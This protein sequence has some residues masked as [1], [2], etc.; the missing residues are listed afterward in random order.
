MSE[1]DRRAILTALQ[2]ALEPR[3]YVLALWEGGSAAW[4]REDRWSD[5]DVQILVDDDRVADA[6]RVVDEALAALSPIEI[7]FE[8]PKPTWHGHDQVF[9]R[10][11]DAGEFRLVDLAVMRRS[12]PHQLAER[13]RHGERRILFDKTGDARSTALDRARHDARLA[14]RTAQLRLAFPLFQSLVTKEL[15]R[16]NPLG[17]LAFYS[18]HTLQPL[19]TLLRIRHCPERFDF[20]PRYA[21]ADLPPERLRRLQSLWFVR[22]VEELEAK[23]EEAE[24]F[25]AEVLRE[26]DEGAPP[27][28]AAPTST[29]PRSI[30]EFLDRY[31]DAFDRLDGDAV[32]G[33]YAVP[34][35]IV[36]RAGYLQWPD[37]ESIRDNMARLCEQY[38]SHGYRRA[39]YEPA[40][41][42]L[43]GER[44]AVVD[45]AWSIDR[46]PGKDDWS[47]HTTYNLIRDRSGW[48]VLLCTAYEEQP[49]DG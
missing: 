30:R 15:L 23:R 4:Q 32:A 45:V 17:A 39:R 43:Q 7:R 36:T 8:A 27:S 20:G 42:I 13:E 26:I 6:I 10:L 28:R 38:R 44:S 40:S 12:S 1:L 34:S 31:R 5:L 2:R 14:D 47:F 22:G 16:G 3:D 48:K 11:R 24:A 35:G 33:L 37:F 49:L 18:S 19:H 9:Y 25:F 29:I 41:F 46:G 21:A